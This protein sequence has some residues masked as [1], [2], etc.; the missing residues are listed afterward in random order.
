M[1]ERNLQYKIGSFVHT[2]SIN[3]KRQEKN[4][5]K[6]KKIWLAIAVSAIVESFAFP[7]ILFP[8]C[9]RVKEEQQEEIYAENRQTW[10][11]AL[12]RFGYGGEK[13]QQMEFEW[14]FWFQK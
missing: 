4:V 3:R 1:N 5:K 14:K 9:I 7:E 8:D 6:R 10:I 13:E 12:R 11:Q 2:L